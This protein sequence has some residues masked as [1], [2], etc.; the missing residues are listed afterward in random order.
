MLKIRAMA[1][2][3]DIPVVYHHGKSGLGFMIGLHLSTAFGDSP[4]LEYMDD[5]P[6]WQPK[7]FQVGFRETVP[8]DADGYVHCPQTPGLGVDWDQGWLRQ[9]GLA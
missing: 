8:I 3:A 4:W 7:G 1:E 6:F 2:G 5:G 9:I